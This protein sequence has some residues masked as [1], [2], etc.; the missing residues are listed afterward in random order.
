MTNIDSDLIFYRP[1]QTT[2]DVE[3]DIRAR[4]KTPN[5]KDIVVK[6]DGRYGMF[7]I[8]FTS[9]G[10]APKDFDGMYTTVDA[11][12][13]VIEKYISKKQ[14]PEPTPVEPKKITNDHADAKGKQTI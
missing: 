2:A 7:I 10:Q 11:A 14:T 3:E 6:A 12:S 8:Q 5:G 13:K 9:G 1:S 4:F